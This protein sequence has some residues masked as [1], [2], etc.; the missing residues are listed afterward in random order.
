VKRQLGRSR[1]RISGCFGPGS[2]LVGLLLELA[3]RKGNMLAR[4]A[5]TVVLSTIVFVVVSLLVGF[6]VAWLTG[7]ALRGTVIG[8]ICGLAAAFV[9]STV[10][11]AVGRS[12]GRPAAENERSSS[13][14]DRR[15]R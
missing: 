14:S 11:T 13:E 6:G 3:A 8:I 4:I 2:D 1:P 9:T 15:A 5:G 7:G 10:S 12:R